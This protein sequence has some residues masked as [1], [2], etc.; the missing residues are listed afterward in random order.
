MYVLSVRV[1]QRFT[2]SGRRPSSRLPG[3]FAFEGI[4]SFTDCRRGRA[5]SPGHPRGEPLCCKTSRL[6]VMMARRPDPHGELILMISD[7]ANGTDDR[8]PVPG[9]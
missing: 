5:G 6:A 1:S 4:H 9:R 7:W 3:R 8:P 2:W